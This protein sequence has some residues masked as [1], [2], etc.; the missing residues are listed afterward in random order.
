MALSDLRSI[1]NNNKTFPVAFSYCRAE[2][3]E[4][5]SFFWTSLKEHWPTQTAPPVVIISDQG[6][7]ILSSLKEQFPEVKHQICEW[8]A[9]E[10]IC[11]KFRQFHTSIEV[12]GGR[13]QEGNEVESLKGFT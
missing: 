13:D 8:H 11:A 5:Y 2:D 3:H 9:A 6:G 12:Q 1:L 7:A 10:A 4:S